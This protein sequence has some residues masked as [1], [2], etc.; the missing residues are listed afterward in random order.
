MTATK[1]EGIGVDVAG[2]ANFALAIGVDPQ[3]LAEHL[4]LTGIIVLERAEGAAAQETVNAIIAGFRAGQKEEKRRR[5][6][7]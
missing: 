6:M 5:G 2:F 3:R 7:I 4:I 1:E